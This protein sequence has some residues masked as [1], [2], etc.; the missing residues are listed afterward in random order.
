MGARAGTGGGK[1][2][3]GERGRR[4]VGVGGSVGV[5]LHAGSLKDSKITNRKTPCQRSR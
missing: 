5:D 3:C 1:C 2:A 4:R